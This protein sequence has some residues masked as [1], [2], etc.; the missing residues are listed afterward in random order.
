MFQPVLFQNLN[1]PQG[2]KKVYWYMAL[3][4]FIALFIYLFYRTEK[5]VTNQ[6]VISVT[7]AKNFSFLRKNIT[8]L[9]PLNRHVIFSLPEG[10]WVFCITLTSK[11]L[12]VKT[13][14]RKVDLVYVPLLFSIGLELFQLLHLTHGRFD[15]WDIAFSIF[16]WGIA[17]YLVAYQNT[18][19][20][21]LE[22]FN[23][24]SAICLLSYLIVYLAHVWQ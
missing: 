15:W 20:N 10:L 3:A 4:R 13:G 6:L 9:L 21:I 5:T 24:R 2:V 16:F 11:F 7:S 8:S 1:L 18:R 22:P 14:A 23:T 17:R 19:Q 12:F